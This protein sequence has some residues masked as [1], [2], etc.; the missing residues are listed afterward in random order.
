MNNKKVNY[1]KISQLNYKTEYSLKK[2][3]IKKEVNYKTY[4]IEYS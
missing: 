4:K 1:K 2:S 3:T